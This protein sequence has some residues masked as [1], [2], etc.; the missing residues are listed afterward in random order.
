MA[1]ENAVDKAV[2][3]TATALALFKKHSSTNATT[4]TREQLESIMTE[5]AATRDG[6][7]HVATYL[8]GAHL[9]QDFFT[10]EGLVTTYNAY[11]EWLLSGHASQPSAAA[12]EPAPAAPEPTP[13]APEPTPAETTKLELAAQKETPAEA[14]PEFKPTP[15]IEPATAPEPEPEPE[16]EAE[17]E[18][19]IVDVATAFAA[20]TDG[21]V[22]ALE[23]ALDAGVDVDAAVD[24]VPLVCAAAGSD[25]TDLMELLVERKANVN[26]PRSADG[27]TP[28]MLAAAGADAD[29]VEML[30][31]HGANASLQGAA[32][33][34]AEAL[35]P[36]GELKALL[37]EAANGM[38]MM[39][40]QQLAAILAP[41][42]AARRVSV[43]AESIDPTKQARRCCR[44]HRCRHRCRRY[45]ARAPSV[46]GRAGQRQT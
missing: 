45:R 42:S 25:S 35:A 5:L 11:V 18:P 17:P 36:N 41:K 16:P 22:D 43:S 44:H 7:Q 8:K 3:R 10:F 26:A 37:G 29:L 1:T 38:G 15:A 4:L 23:A 30:L 40:A 32:G 12:P 21:D 31:H 14:E 19:G 9:E 20:V 28:L 39:N 24:G 27:L 13:A 6:E 34:T 33:E 46:R 2:R